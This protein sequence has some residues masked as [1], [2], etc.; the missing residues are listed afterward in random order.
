[1]YASEPARLIAWS[2]E[3]GDLFS[4]CAVYHPHFAIDDLVQGLLDVRG[5]TLDASLVPL[6]FVG[7]PR[8][9]GRQPSTAEARG[10]AR[11]SD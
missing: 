11:G 3:A 10:R 6:P 4:R 7:H 9:A 8:R 1:M 2:P 5:R